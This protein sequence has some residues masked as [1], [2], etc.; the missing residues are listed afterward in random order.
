MPSRWLRAKTWFDKQTL[1]GGSTTG[2]WN[3]ES[4]DIIVN[5]LRVEIRASDAL[6]AAGLT[7]WL[8]TEPSFL[9]LPPHSTDDPDVAVAIDDRLTVHTL[10]RLRHAAITAPAPTV[11]IVDGLGDADILAVV[12][13]QVAA[14]LPHTA[15]NAARLV[16]S[17]IAVNSG[18]GMMPP[19]MVGALLK[20]IRWLQQEVLVPNSLD[21]S[22]IKPREADVLRL[23]ADGHDTTTVAQKLSIAE[24]TVGN[25]LHGMIHRLGLRNRQ[26][27]VAHA[28]RLGVI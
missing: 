28:I 4:G 23:I 8:S 19:G 16:Q 12:E 26:Q 2:S 27:A 15:V 20:R 13:C 6:S 1:P 24:R 25:V 21:S 17:V 18:G 10:A 11:L 7:S 5:Q 3:T 14:I 22:G 9:V